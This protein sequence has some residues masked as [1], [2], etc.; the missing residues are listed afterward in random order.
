MN[1][2]LC[3]ADISFENEAIHLQ[4]QRTFKK[5]EQV[6]ALVTKETLVNYYLINKLKYKI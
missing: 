6:N 5:G 2:D 3:C 4:H 1:D